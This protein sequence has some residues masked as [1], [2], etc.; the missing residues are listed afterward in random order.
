MT[1]SPT[2]LQSAS[3]ADADDDA[4]RLKLLV[5]NIT[6][7]AI[8]ML[9]VEGRV[10]SWN[11]GAE[12]LTG[13]AA[14]EIIGRHFSRFFGD[15]DKARGLPKTALEAALR[16][17]CFEADGWRLRKDGTRF[18][19]NAIVEA[20]RDD[21]GELIGFAKVT[22]DISERR[23]AQQGQIESEQ[24][25]R[26]LVQGVVDYAIYMLDPI[27]LVTNW[28]VGAERLKGYAPAEVIG[29]HFSLFYTAEDRAAG[30]PAR[31]LETA[32]RTGKFEAE[33]WRVRKDG[34]RFVALVVIDAIR[35]AGGKLIGYAKITRDVTQQRAERERLEES[36]RMFRLLVNGI[37]DYA[38]YMLDLNGNVSSWNAGAERIKG[39]AASE[40][41]GE[42]FSRFYTDTDRAAG[43]PAQALAAAAETGRFEA[44]GWRV[45]KDGT[46]LWASVVIDAIRDETGRL[47]GYAKITRDISERR[48]AQLALQKMQTQLAEAQKMDALGQLTGGVAHDFNNL[49]MIVSG[50]LSTLKKLTAHD[51]KGV[52]AAEAV[53]IATQRGAALT[54]QLLTFARRQQVNPTA[55]SV[56]GQIAAL[57]DVLNSA[58]GSSI[59]LTLDIPASTWPVNVDVNEFE[60]ALVNLVLNARDAMP[61]GGS[62]MISTEN[63]GDSG[64]LGEHVALTVAD[65]GMGIA[66]DVI[67]K[68]FDPFF[69][70]KGV[71]KGTGLGLSQ[72]FGFAHQAG[73]S[74]KAHSTLGMGTRITLCLPRSR[75]LP[76]SA[77]DADAAPGIAVTGTVLL[78]EDNPDVSAASVG[79]LEQLGYRVETVSDAA[80]ALAVLESGK[81]IN[82]VISDVV[83]P[84]RIDGFAL[85]R[86]LREKNPALPVLLVTGY[87][88]ASREARDEFIILPKPYDVHELR[89]ALLRVSSAAKQASNLVAFDRSAGG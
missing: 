9:D 77:A 26:M 53:Q 66:P 50:H 54:R 80:S 51:P 4:A 89:A 8:Y 11:A 85:A 10:T 3:G 71:G 24:R 18:W 32:A 39:Y 57:V 72:V 29:R 43:V 87:A 20:I 73:G 42:H 52:R 46:F 56:G 38:L 37:T 45:R 35:D 69:T 76:G 70:T 83:M 86:A 60:I 28:N 27:G 31:A 49:L 33:G 30:L 68:I 79:M 74:V 7:Y 40:I 5:E 81:R 25:F 22:R 58:L 82:A 14:H 62:V 19:A 17:G 1:Q 55:V 23:V 64:E 13:Y 65:T 84:G 59:Q 88:D 21:A 34:S 67:G 36:E 6:G 63:V 75:A 16:V 47:V 44:E 41:V 12:K 61:D 48:E 78:V 2:K 15:D